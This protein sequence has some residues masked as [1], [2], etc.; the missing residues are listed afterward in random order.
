MVVFQVLS[1]FSLRLHL[2]S[3]FSIMVG[4]AGF[5]SVVTRYPHDKLGI[6]VF[7]NDDSYGGIITEIVKLRIA[8]HLLGLEPIDF[9]ARY[10]HPLSFN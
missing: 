7:S 8:D 4:H 6:A 3:P 2:S 1:P 10:V 5:K 9:N